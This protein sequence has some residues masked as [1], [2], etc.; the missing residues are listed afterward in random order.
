[1]PERVNIDGVDLTLASPDVH[2]SHWI[3]YNDYVR[4]L[5][6]AWLR[7]SEVEVPLNPRIIG[8]PGLGK[9]TLA[10]AVAKHLDRAVYIFQCTMD[11][12]PED[13]VVTP[14]LTEDKR[15]DYRAS[16]LVTAAI[17]GGIVLLDEGNRMPERSWASL[18][19][20]GRSVDETWRA[21]WPRKIH[22]HQNCR[23][24]VLAHEYST[25]AFTSY[26]VTSR[27]A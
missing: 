21:K 11:T 15:I 16:A 22:A 7:L 2:D 6:A 25:P 9:T 10:C 12:R 17:R 20:I 14:V 27:V 18:G 5:E 8:E 1:M 13:L 19:A 26:R 4:Q 3:D 23:L 24:C